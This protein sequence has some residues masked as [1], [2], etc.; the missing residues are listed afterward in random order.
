MSIIFVILLCAVSCFII[1]LAGSSH[2][3]KIFIKILAAFIML[4]GTAP[5]LVI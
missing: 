1:E 5:I 3:A 2:I 4:I